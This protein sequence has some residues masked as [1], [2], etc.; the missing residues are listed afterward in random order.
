MLGLDVGSVQT[1]LLSS[2]PFCTGHRVVTEGGQCL[3]F[4]VVQFK[5]LKV[6]DNCLILYI[7]IYIYI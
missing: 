5:V 7:Y 3:A 6:K 1:V 4:A 2:W